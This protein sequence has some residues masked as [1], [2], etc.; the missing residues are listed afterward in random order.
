[1]TD[2]AAV[3]L[4]TAVMSEAVV[5]TLAQRITSVAVHVTGASYFEAETQR[6]SRWS[7]RSVL[8][9]RFGRRRR[10]ILPFGSGTQLVLRRMSHDEPA[11]T[12]CKDNG[13]MH[14]REAGNSSNATH[15]DGSHRALYVRFRRN[16]S[17]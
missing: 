7:R 17:P 15:V 1:M 9:R 16:K 5:A 10:K 6:H 4:V 14:T 13:A 8:R 12:P 11:W 2:L 3:I